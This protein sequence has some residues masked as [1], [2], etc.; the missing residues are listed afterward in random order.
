MTV[1]GWIVSDTRNYKQFVA[2]R[3]CEI[4]DKS[5]ATQWRWIPSKENVADDSTRMALA[6]LS[7][8]A[9]WFI[10][11]D[12]LREPEECWSNRRNPEQTVEEIRPRAMGNVNFHDASVS[13]NNYS[14]WKKLLRVQCYVLRF[15]DNLKSN[16][17]NADLHLGIISKEEFV[18]GEKSL[19]KHAQTKFY[20]DEIAILENNGVVPKTSEIYKTLPFLDSDKILRCDGRLQESNVL[21]VDT[22]NPIILSKES[23]ITKLL[24]HEHHVKFL[25]INHESAINEV[26]QRFFIV[27]LRSAMKEY[28]KVVN[29]AKSKKLNQLYREWLH[30][31]NRE[32]QPL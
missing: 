10:G 23:H 28:V 13:I 7:P 29:S 26:R 9:R 30:Y 1:L 27:N 4:L 19:F 14:T 11:P 12:F 15:I 24:L 5:E 18:K 20:S 21:S 3:I 32:L 25:H 6:N 8:K 17:M 2:S 22:K 16:R 31:H